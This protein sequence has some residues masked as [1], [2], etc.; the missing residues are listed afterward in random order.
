MKIIFI[1]LFF[2]LGTI[3]RAQVSGSV[4]LAAQNN[5]SGIKIKFEAHSGTATTDSTTTDAAGNYSINLSGGLY[6]ITFNHSGYQTAYYNNNSL[7]TI[8]SA[9]TLT[10][11]TLQPGNSIQVSGGNVSGTWL[12]NNVYFVNGNIVVQSGS[13][14]N[15]QHGVIVKFT[16]NYSLTVHGTLNAVGY[17]WSPIL[18]TT[19]NQPASP[20]DWKGIHI[21][22]GFSTLSYCTLEY[23]LRGMWV[24]NANAKI[25]DNIIRNFLTRGIELNNSS[26]TISNNKIYDY[27]IQDFS[28]GILFGGN[29]LP[30]IECNTIYNGKGR[31]ILS[32]AGGTIKNNLIYNISNGP[33]IEC[34]ASATTKIENNIIHNCVK[35][36]EIGETVTIQVTPSILNNTIYNNGIGI[37]MGDF[38]SKSTIIGNIIVSNTVGI[39]ENSCSFCANTPSVIS[40][41]NVWNNLNG[42]YNGVQFTA[43]GQTVTSNANGTPIDSYFNIS[44]DPLFVNNTAPHLSPLSPCFNAGNIQYSPNIGCNVTNLCVGMETSLPSLKNE[45]SLKIFPNP[46]QDFLVIEN[47]VRSKFQSLTITDIS[48]RNISLTPPYQNNDKWTVSTA[49]FSPGCYFLN[50]QFESGTKMNTRFIKQ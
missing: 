24:W 26:A 23:G 3:S 41:N 11:H 13:V 17:S 15:I 47:P 28:T 7:V 49:D 48:G 35:G 33:G 4:F 27:Q 25:N 8:S 34:V 29:S 12:T 43:I 31:G 6:K 2:V 14:L 18:F 42:N 50:V 19:I 21:E 40:H 46:C 5:H 36:F 37:S 39:Y 32:Q 38:F 9:T 20:G 1:V 45:L 44:V 10:S 16:G 30:T 22:S